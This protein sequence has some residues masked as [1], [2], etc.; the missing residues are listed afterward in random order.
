MNTRL[1][2]SMTFE[3]RYRHINSKLE[4][5]RTDGS[6]ARAE[7]SAVLRQ[8]MTDGFDFNEIFDVIFPP[9]VN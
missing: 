7:M 4:E 5:E 1:A 8:L 9:R 6:N 2:A 3:E